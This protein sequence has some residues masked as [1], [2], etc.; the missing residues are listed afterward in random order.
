[1]EANGDLDVTNTNMYRTHP[2]IYLVPTGNIQGTLK[3]F[4]LK[5]G[6]IKN[7]RSDID[8]PMPDRVIEVVNAQGKISR[9]E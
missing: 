6:F 5:T 3:V 7:P 2:G 4:Y 9:N 1:M 8:F